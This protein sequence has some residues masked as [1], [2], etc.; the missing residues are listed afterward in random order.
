M[1]QYRQN[2]VEKTFRKRV[3]GMTEESIKLKMNLKARNP[4]FEHFTPVLSY[5]SEVIMGYRRCGEF[6]NVVYSSEGSSSE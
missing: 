4:T 5:S 1:A 6:I 3:I 2:I